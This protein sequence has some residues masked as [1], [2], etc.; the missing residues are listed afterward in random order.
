ML[1][2]KLEDFFDSKSLD[3]LAEL[4]E[5]ITKER[6][7]VKDTDIKYRVINHWDEKG[8]IRFARKAEEG[9]RKF[10]LVDFIWI[11]VVNELRSFGV[12]LSDIQ[13]IAKDIY[14]PLPMKEL[15]DNL[16]ENIDTLKDYEANDKQEFIDFIKSGEY[17]SAEFP[18]IDINYLQIAIVEAIT[19]R[20]PISLLIFKNGDWFPF[21]KSKESYYPADLLY[22]KDFYSHISVSITE[23]MFRYLLEDYFKL[24][25]DEMHIFNKHEAKLLEYIVEE[26]FKKVFVLFKSKKHEPIEITKG[27]DAKEKIMRIIRAR[28]YREFILVD[29]ENNEFRVKE[30]KAEQEAKS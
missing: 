11:K 8:L 25:L 6:L 2:V 24:Y 30:S 9:H 4:Y 13:K 10:S 17:K 7:T 22:K 29:K 23:I 26:N 21:I 14:E 16:A 19:T 20:E 12:K 5:I 18:Q 27:E 1:A 15:M 3:K 28:E